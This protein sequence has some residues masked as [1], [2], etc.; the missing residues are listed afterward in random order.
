MKMDDL[1]FKVYEHYNG[2]LILLSVFTNQNHAERFGSELLPAMP[3]DHTIIV[4]QGY[5]LYTGSGH[6][7]IKC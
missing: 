3:S 1:P 7:N 6:A 2:K 4:V 5:L